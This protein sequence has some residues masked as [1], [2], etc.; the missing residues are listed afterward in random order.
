MSNGITKPMQQATDQKFIV[1]FTKYFGKKT[2]ITVNETEY[3]PDTITSTVQS[4]VDT[5]ADVVTKRGNYSQA[6]ATA[7]A[8]VAQT[9][10]T[11]DNA[12]QA[13]LLQYGN[14]PAVL[15][16]FGLAARKVG[17][18]SVATKQAA[19]IQAKATRVAR[20]TM[21]PRQKEQIKGV[22]A[23]ASPDASVSNPSV[24]PS[25]TVTVGSNPAVVPVPGVGS[26]VIAPN[27]TG[28]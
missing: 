27:G 23:P 20:N 25:A 1:A 15:A 28:H 3:T 18:R 4:R 17:T 8:T 13:V 9:K 10:Q 24:A 7:K 12:K 6:V 16:E 26:T 21:G 5:Q 22:V 14:N 11:Y 19:I 2:K